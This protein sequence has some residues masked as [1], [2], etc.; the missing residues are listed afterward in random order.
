MNISNSLLHEDIH[1]CTHMDTQTHTH[2]HKFTLNWLT[3]CPRHP[4]SFQNYMPFT[5]ITCLISSYNHLCQQTTLRLLVY[6]SVSC[7]SSCNMTGISDSVYQLSYCSVM[8]LASPAL[9]YS[10]CQGSCPLGF[11]SFFM[12]F[13]CADHTSHVPSSCLPLA[14]CWIFIYRPKVLFPFLCLCIYLHS[15]QCAVQ[16]FPRQSFYFEGPWLTNQG[17][18]C[19]NIM[20]RV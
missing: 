3:S 12:F 11:W 5:Y 20:H 7:S 8:I 16:H 13:D 6:F 19:L 4:A 17:L 14:L 15:F 10:L 18:N 1:T 9:T 2:M